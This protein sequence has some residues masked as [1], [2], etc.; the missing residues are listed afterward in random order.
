MD[1]L[2]A[3]DLR[4]SDTYGLIDTV[5]STTSKVIGV[6]AIHWHALA[7]FYFRAL[8]LCVLGYLS[9]DWEFETFSTLDFPPSM[10]LQFVRMW[11]LSFL[12]TRARQ[13]FSQSETSMDHFKR[14]HIRRP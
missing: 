1:M 3:M 5:H 9:D 2:R 6:D 14:T 12:E 10:R 7:E 8:S 13:L 11:A 4:E